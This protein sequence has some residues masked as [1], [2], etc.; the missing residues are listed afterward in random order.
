MIAV[1]SHVYAPTIHKRLFENLRNLKNRQAKSE[2]NGMLRHRDSQSVSQIKF[3]E[4]HEY[5]P[6]SNP[7]KGLYQ[8]VWPYLQSMLI[9]ESIL[10]ISLN[11]IFKKWQNRHTNTLVLRFSQFLHFNVRSTFL[12]LSDEGIIGVH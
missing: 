5:A 2:I 11:C 12:K 9:P 10:F 3:P 1:R 4:T 8:R 7:I 6:N